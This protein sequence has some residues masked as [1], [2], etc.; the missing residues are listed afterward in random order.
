[1]LLNIIGYTLLVLVPIL[2]IAVIIMVAKDYYE[3][4]R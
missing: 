1:M 4:F 2:I 3:E